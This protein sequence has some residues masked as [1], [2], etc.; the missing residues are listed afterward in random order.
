MKIWNTGP[1]K[2]DVKMGHAYGVFPS[3]F[4]PRVCR[5]L[6]SVNIDFKKHRVLPFRVA[7]KDGRWCVRPSYVFFR[8]EDTKQRTTILVFY[9]SHAAS[10]MACN[11]NGCNPGN[12]SS[13]KQNVLARFRFAG[14]AEFANQMPACF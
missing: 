9:T 10:E 1:P 4:V 2:G 5:T 14:L 7:E 11:K 8:E 3:Y 6:D 13:M 12:L